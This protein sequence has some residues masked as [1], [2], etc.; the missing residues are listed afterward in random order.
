MDFALPADLVAYLDELDHFIAHEIKPL[1]EVDDNI[2][3]FDHRREWARTDFDNGGL[4]RHEW[5]ALLRR[6]KDIADKRGHLRFAI[7]KRYGGKDGSN[8]WMAVIR[9]HFASRGLG[10]HN[11]LQNEHSIVGNFPLVTMLDRY[12]SDD[13]KA[14]IE[15]SI[16]GKYRITFGL[17]EPEH[18][19]DATHME[20]RAV[21]ATRD[22]ISGWVING[23]KMWTTG[24][25]VAT[26][27]ALFAR[28]S[29]SDGDARGI[30]CF[31]VPAN[32]NGVKVEEYLWTFNMPTDHPRV[33]FTDVFVPEAALF[34]EVGGGL[35]LAQCFV[36]EN[37]IRQAASSLGA[38]V[39][40]IQESVKY[41]RERKP[42]GKALAE[43]QAIQWPL[44]ELATQ[45][46]ML[47]LLIRQDGVGDGSTHPGADRAH[48]SP[49]R[50][51]CAITGRTGCA[52]RPPIAP[53]RCMAAWAT[54]ATRR[55]NTSIA[56][57]AVTVSPKAARKSRNGRSPGSCS[58][59]WERGNIEGSA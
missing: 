54:P 35:S 38:A 42:F 52:A 23:E 45:A 29:G 49:T 16:T 20:T 2:R 22:G 5:E 24:M 12:G 11:D 21:P 58:D 25:H 46:E 37:R 55:S 17:T 39:Y 31:L 14:M 8:L 1:Q 6:A 36:H 9:E 4:P 41:A 33:S 27:C 57:T 53:C 56:T 3:F 7:P 48:A 44:V 10:L 28:T 13:Q 59:I 51:R 19:S 50:S 43:N 32:S 15:G 34:G 40:C 26:H 30:T 47:R 18:G